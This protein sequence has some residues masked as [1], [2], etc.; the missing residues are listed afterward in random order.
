MWKLLMSVK[1]LFTNKDKN[2]IIPL[3][4]KTWGNQKFI[5]FYIFQEILDEVYSLIK[6]K[7]HETLEFNYSLL[8]H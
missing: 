8:K 6:W 3:Q 7:I 4:G 1:A 5:N 2:K